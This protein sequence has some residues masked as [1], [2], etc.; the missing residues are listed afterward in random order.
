MVFS[1]FTQVTVM[2]MAFTPVTEVQN[3]GA[4]HILECLGLGSM[5]ILLSEQLGW[6]VIKEHKQQ[7]E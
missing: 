5:H 1:Y 2:A 3:N 7:V 4:I 6:F